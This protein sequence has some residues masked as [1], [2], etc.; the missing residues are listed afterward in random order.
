MKA[1][2]LVAFLFP[3]IVF[4]QTENSTKQNVFRLNV[5]NPGIEYE[6][7]LSEKSKLSVNAGFG[8]SMSYPELT[9]FQPDYAFFLSSFL[10]LHY[11]FIYNLDRRIA[12][13]KNI[14]Y[15][16]GDFVGLKIIGRGVEV[17]QSNTLKR[18]DNVDFSVGPTWGI[19]R[20]FSK[21]HLLFNAGPVYYFDTKGN[22]G[23][24]PIMLELNI[25]YNVWKSK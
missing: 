25:G 24:Y 9:S 6:H 17:G 15:N 4:G 3:A 1:L 7:S 2:L 18:T 19:Q 11:K 13:K 23:F 5:I 16:S 8:V 20:S 10:D 21:I 14:D 12:M 22:S